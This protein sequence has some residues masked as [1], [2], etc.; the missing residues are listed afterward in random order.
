MIGDVYKSSGKVNWGKFIP[1]FLIGSIVCMFLGMMYGFLVNINPL[2]YV[3]FLILFG[4]MVVVF[5][6]SVFIWRLGESRNKIINFFSGIIM[7]F[8][9][10]T[11]AWFSLMPGTGWLEVLNVSEVWGFA[12]NYA[13]R[14]SFSVGK[15]GRSGVEFSGGLLYALYLVE[16]LAF[17]APA[18][19]SLFKTDVYCERCNTRTGT[20]EYS[21]PYTKELKEELVAVKDG[22]F[23]K[24]LGEMT[25]N[26]VTGF[27]AGTTVL[28]IEDNICSVCKDFR[29]LRI[30][31]GVINKDEKGNKDFKKRVL[32]VNNI[33]AET[34]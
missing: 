3:N 17:L 1:A 18:L 24:V 23:N 30:E 34:P 9:G 25:P 31:E 2:I 28:K 6:V 33:E 4:A 15:F 11:A 14:N 19:V 26:G 12:F 8:M 13:E 7:G 21:T 16:F 5:F 32:I 27:P 29:V 20:I 22:R 10:V